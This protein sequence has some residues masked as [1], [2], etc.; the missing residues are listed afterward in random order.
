[1]FKCSMQIHFKCEMRSNKLELQ[2]V[3]LITH[4]DF[5]AILHHKYMH[6][7]RFSE[8]NSPVTGGKGGI[9]KNCGQKRPKD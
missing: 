2:S 4:D 9:W 6:V 7:Y 5:Y 3:C 8:V 1:M